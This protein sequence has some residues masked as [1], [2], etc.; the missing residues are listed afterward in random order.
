MFRR[1]LRL[2]DNMN[3]YLENISPSLEAK[4]EERAIVYA[5]VAIAALLFFAAVLLATFVAINR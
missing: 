1:G 3:H 4:P 2:R 5:L